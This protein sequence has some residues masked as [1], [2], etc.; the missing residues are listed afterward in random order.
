MHWSLWCSFLR[1]MNLI[2]SR[3]EPN[4]DICDKMLK[5][6]GKINSLLICVFWDLFIYLWILLCDVRMRRVS[7]YLLLVVKDGY[8][9]ECSLQWDRKMSFCITAG[10]VRWGPRLLGIFVINFLSAQLKYFTCIQM[11][12]SQHQTKF[13]SLHTK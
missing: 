3:G 10:F 13:Y 1:F 9:L 12:T 11:S 2:W 5:T 8:K 7:N 6:Y 4:F